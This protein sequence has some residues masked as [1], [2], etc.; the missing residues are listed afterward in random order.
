MVATVNALLFACAAAVASRQG[1]HPAYPPFP[2]PSAD[3]RNGDDRNAT[4]DP[5]T[6]LTTSKEHQELGARRPTV[7]S[8]QQRLLRFRRN[9]CGSM[10]VVCKT[11]SDTESARGPASGFRFP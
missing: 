1:R 3:F 11:A 6:I 9:R 10:L 8:V 4:P 5:E 2:T 7:T